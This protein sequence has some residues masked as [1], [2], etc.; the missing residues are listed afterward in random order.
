MAEETLMRRH[1]SG[2]GQ[3]KTCPSGEGRRRL[4]ILGDVPQRNDLSRMDGQ[5]RNDD[6]GLGLWSADLRSATDQGGQ[7]VSWERRQEA[8][9][10]R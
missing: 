5:V 3:T 4:S 1:N 6:V 2:T 8:T 9:S 10:S 7:P